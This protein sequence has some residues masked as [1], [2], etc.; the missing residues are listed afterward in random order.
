[1]GSPAK[2]RSRARVI[3]LLGRQQ[4]A[5]AP[6]AVGELFK[7]ALDAG[8]RNVWVDFWEAEK[9][10]TVR[11]DGLGMREED[12]LGKW[13]V[14]A[15]DSRHGAV[16]N[17]DGW[18]KFADAEQKKWLSRPSYGEKGIGRLSVATLG[19]ITLLW[20]VWGEKTERRGV[21]CLV[22][23]NLF[24]HPTKLFEELPIPFL[25]L[26]RAPR[27][28]DVIA[29][30]GELRAADSVKAMLRDQDWSA[31]LRNQLRSDL[32]LDVT[33]AFARVDL[34]WETGTTFCILNPS[35]QV[36]ELF[37][38][39]VLKR[40]RVTIVRL[41]GSSRFTH[42]RHFGIHSIITRTAILRFI[43]LF[44]GKNCPEQIAIGLLRI[45]TNV[46]TTFVSRY[47]KTASPKDL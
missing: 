27:K 22:H 42:F 34:R 5:D 9:V 29:L 33:H 16:R 41:I 36:E 2:F 18:A 15:T 21:L 31:D 13:L 45:S 30:F 39:G 19:R 8:A 35:D 47:R 26:K 32:E 44:P 7:N 28:S 23:W 1:M 43:R 14:L 11:D 6:T 10:L 25:Q 20:T 38:K 40:N 12:V 3:D 24:Q 37:L 4:I 46:T 17:D